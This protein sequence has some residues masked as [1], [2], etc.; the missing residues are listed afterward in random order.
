MPNHSDLGSVRKKID[1]K[2]QTMYFLLYTPNWHTLLTL[3]AQKLIICTDTFG[4]VYLTLSC[5]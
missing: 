1:I 3:Q 2:D 5:L 4:S